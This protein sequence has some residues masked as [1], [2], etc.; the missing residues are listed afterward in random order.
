MLILALLSGPL[1]HSLREFF[2]YSRIDI[3]I[4]KLRSEYPEIQQK[5][6]IRHLNVQLKGT[7][8]YITILTIAP[9]GVITDEYRQTAQKRI[10]D[11]L[12]KMGVQSMD[13]VLK[14]IPVEIEEYQLIS[15]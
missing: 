14:I 10:F 15:P 1:T 7:T 3:E 2:I 9:K 4:Q 11:S 6:Q 8:A 12:S 13:V 5:S